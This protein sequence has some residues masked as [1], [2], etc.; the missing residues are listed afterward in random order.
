M[1]VTFCKTKVGNGF[2][3]AVND[4]WLFVKKEY[5]LQVIDD[6]AMSC[7]FTTIEED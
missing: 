2:K 5:L 4:E 6:D 3:I 7:Q 1:K